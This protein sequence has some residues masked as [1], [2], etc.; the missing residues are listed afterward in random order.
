MHFL[1]C[2]QIEI[3]G[4]KCNILHK[5]IANALSNYKTVNVFGDTYIVKINKVTDWED[6]RT[7]LSNITRENGCDCKFIMTPI[8]NGGYYNGWIPKD[9]WPQ[10]K[11]IIN[12]NG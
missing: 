7:S 12:S 10:I 11:D 3:D 6:I 4:E 9:K 1:L 5:G 8:I 2:Y